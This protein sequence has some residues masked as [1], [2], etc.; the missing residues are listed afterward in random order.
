LTDLKTLERI[1]PGKKELEDL[2]EFYEKAVAATKS[3]EKL[4]FKKMIKQYKTSHF[5]FTS[6]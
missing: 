3:E 4:L 6:R 5:L 2:K 1:I